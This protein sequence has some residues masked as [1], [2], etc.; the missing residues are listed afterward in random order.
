MKGSY[1]LLLMLKEPKRVKV[2]KLGFVDFKAGWYAYVGSGMNSLIGRVARHFK[3]NKKL[4][5]HID[6][7]T[8]VADDVVVFLLPNGKECELAKL[9]NGF[10]CVEGFG[11]SDCSCRSHLFYLGNFK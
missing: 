4:R 8:T 6:Y 9:F 11:C 3:R 2:G 5:W 7:L 10:E 1:V